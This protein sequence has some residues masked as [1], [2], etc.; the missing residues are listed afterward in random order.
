MRLPED[1][2]RNRETLPRPTDELAATVDSV[3]Q[4]FGAFFQFVPLLDRLGA[5]FSQKWF[6]QKMM[7]R[8]FVSREWFLPC[9]FQIRTGN[10]ELYLSIDGSR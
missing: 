9:C 3:G 1:D 7:R 8:S 2:R 5:S 4:R 6:R 10:I